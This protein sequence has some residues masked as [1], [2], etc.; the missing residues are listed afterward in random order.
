MMMMMMI[1]FMSFIWTYI[2]ASKAHCLK[3][4]DHKNLYILLFEVLGACFRPYN[5]FFS[6]QTLFSEF[7]IS[8][9]DGC[10]TYT[11][12]LR[13]AFRNA[14]FTYTYFSLEWVGKH[15]FLQ[16][17][18]SHLDNCSVPTFD[19][20]I[21]LW[22]VGSCKLPLNSVLIAILTEFC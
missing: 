18:P 5:A 4:I 9:L 1:C 20:T 11:S 3:S 13:C 8:N 22:G 14:D 19:N 7:G 2:I 12:S 6:L 17:T 15:L 10:V 16:H 21:L